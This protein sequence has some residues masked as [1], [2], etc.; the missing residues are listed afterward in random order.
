VRQAI[1]RASRGGSRQSKIENPKL[2]GL[3][4]GEE[5][6]MLKDVLEILTSTPEKLRDEIATMSPKGMKTRP[7]PNKWSVQEILAHLDDVEEHAMRARVAA[8]IEQHEPVLIPFDQEKRVVEMRYDR[9]DPR[10]TLASFARQRQANV[11]WLRTLKPAQLKRKGFHQT[12]GEITADE[13][14]H[15]WAFHDLGHLKQILEVK[16]CS[17]WPRIGNMQAFYK[18]S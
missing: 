18:L 8:M 10:R 3:Y 11:R 13:M 17:I 4:S 7:A 6:A 16:R 9:K 14:I 15:E 2:L 5:F 1:R 12:V